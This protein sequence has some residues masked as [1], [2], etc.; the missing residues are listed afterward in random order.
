MS[1]SLRFG[2]PIDDLLE[3]LYAQH[4]A[5]DA[6]VSAYFMARAAE[7][8]LDWNRFDDRTHEFLSDKFIALDR[9]KAEFCYH[10][11]PI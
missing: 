10:V 11:C 5:Q 3:R 1:G 8:S 6:G 9:S 7:G 2:S 4:L